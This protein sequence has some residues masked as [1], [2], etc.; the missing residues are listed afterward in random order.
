VS[1]V[2]IDGYEHKNKAMVEDGGHV[3]YRKGLQSEFFT[4]ILDGK[5]EVFSGRQM[6]TTE[7]LRFAI[8]FPELLSRTQTDYA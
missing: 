4:F 8:L 1:H 3:L 7:V 2:D 5:A 6:F